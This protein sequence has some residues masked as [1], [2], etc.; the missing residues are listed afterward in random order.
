MRHDDDDD[1]QSALTYQHQGIPKYASDLR[2]PK[3]D[4]LVALVSF[5]NVVQGLSIISSSV[6]L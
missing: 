3:F 2:K 6:Y 5:E 4:W 1:D